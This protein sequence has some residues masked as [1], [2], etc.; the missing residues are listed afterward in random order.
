M[1]SALADG[2]QA[3]GI[4]IDPATI[5]PG[6]P[7]RSRIYEKPLGDPIYNNLRFDLITAFDV[8]EHIEDDRAAV[9]RWRGARRF[10]KHR[11]GFGAQFPK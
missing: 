10:R 11:R 9:D 1:L 5:H 7:L 3:W 8:L 4:E 6:N 2:A